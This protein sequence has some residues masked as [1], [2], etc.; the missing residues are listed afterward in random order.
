MKAEKAAGASDRTNR[1][2]DDAGSIDIPLAWWRSFSQSALSAWLRGCAASWQATA[3]SRSGAPWRPRPGRLARTVCVLGAALGWA[4]VAGAGVEVLWREI[5]QLPPVANALPVFVDLD[6]DGIDEIVTGGISPADL[7]NFETALTVFQAVDPG[8]L[9]RTAIRPGPQLLGLVSVDHTGSPGTVLASIYE[10]PLGR[11]I[12]YAGPDLIPI[13]SMPLPSGGRVVMVADVDADGQL[14]MLVDTSSEFNAGP[15]MLL[16]YATGAVEWTGSQPATEVTAAQLDADPAL[17]IVLSGSIGRVLDGGTRLPEWSWPAGFGAKVVTGR[18]EDDPS[19][20]GMLVADG[21]LRVFRA[22]PY[23]PLREFADYRSDPAVLIGING[24][25]DEVYAIREPPLTFGRVSV[26]SGALTPLAPVQFGAL[27]PRVGRLAAATAPV[28]TLLASHAGST[29]GFRLIDLDSGQVL[30][31]QRYDRQIFTAAFVDAAGS[32]DP[33]VAS[34]RVASSPSRADLELRD[35]V[36]GVVLA[37]RSSAIANYNFGG[38]GPAGLIAANMDDQPGDE[39]IL[40]G[41][42]S[43]GG[44]VALIDGATLQ[45]RWRI[46]SSSSY[47]EYAEPY[48]WGVLDFDLNGI[49]D[50]V[51]AVRSRVGSGGVQLRVLSGLDGSLLWQSI[52]LQELNPMRN[53]LLAGAIDSA[54]GEEIVIATSR[55]MYAFDVQSRLV[56]WTVKAPPSAPI[57]GLASWGSGDDCRI[58]TRLATGVVEALGC[59]DRVLRETLSLPPSTRWFG[60]LDESGDMLAASAGGALWLS[61][62]GGP[63]QQAMAHLGLSLGSNLPWAVNGDNSGH[64]LIASSSSQLAL[65]RIGG[66]A[67]F[68]SGFE[69][70]P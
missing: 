51:L 39:L 10:P 25:R 18:F 35:S 59:N 40:I 7:G 29:D 37:S 16:D 15:P 48:G 27:P 2:S 14:E 62:S 28:A 45:D 33:N 19:V 43:L 61:R 49:S 22:S 54:P 67:I 34:L 57:V 58:A 60:S 41:S 23:S 1:V 31:Q 32:G 30:Y 64:E 52:T 55:A 44:E 65:L 6:G 5:A 38:S 66:D 26:V 3:P 20:P 56:S 24:G 68:A 70:A 47:M 42:A 8:G 4:A 12:E 13:R 36:T 17:E 53:G 69:L 11:M 46:A 21:Q 50:V 63:F 9:I